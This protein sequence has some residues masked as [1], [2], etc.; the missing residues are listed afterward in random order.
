[1]CL[2]SEGS[3]ASCLTPPT[4][5]L[6][7][8][9]HVPA[10]THAATTLQG[11]GSPVMRDCIT[12][13]TQL[14]AAGAEGAVQRSMRNSFLI[15]AGGVM[16]GWADG[17]VGGVWNMDVGE[18]CEVH[19]LPPDLPGTPTHPLP[20]PRPTPQTWPTPC[21]PITRISTTLT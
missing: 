5:F 16:G 9:Q 4:R 21:T 1:M 13:V 7:P 15:S 10:C 6:K 20:S 8:S 3:D 18:S 2:C 17:G 12:R 19:W 14:L 11:A